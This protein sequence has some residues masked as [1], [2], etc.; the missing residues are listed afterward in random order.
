ME[1]KDAQLASCRKTTADSFCRTVEFT[2]S[3]AFQVNASGALAEVTC[4]GRQSVATSTPRPQTG[5]PP[6]TNRAPQTA[7]AVIPN[8]TANATPA[9]TPQQDYVF[10][11]GHTNADGSVTF[12]PTLQVSAFGP[13]M[14]GFTTITNAR[15]DFD[16]AYQGG[17]GAYTASRY[18]GTFANNVFRGTWS[19]NEN[20][21]G[22]SYVQ[23]TCDPPSARGELVWGYFEIRF[24]SDRRSFI[25]TKTT[26]DRAISQA[27][28]WDKNAWK[29]TLTGRADASVAP[30]V[31]AS[32][33]AATGPNPTFANPSSSSPARTTATRTTQRVSQPSQPREETVADRIAR[34]AAEAAEQR[35]KDEARQGVNRAID[36]LIKR[37]P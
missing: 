28:D 36:G 10:A 7:A 15:S 3:S 13:E 16:A 31:Q 6:G 2:S 14:S 23:R 11:T 17:I 34:E 5:T 29:G 22:L 33:E 32:A 21:Q 1:S 37:R 19:E 30:G 25:G 35:A 24:T 26:C 9:P 8:P 20:E 4:T 18:T 12:K 27:N